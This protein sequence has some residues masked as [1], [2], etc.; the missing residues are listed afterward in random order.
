MPSPGNVC[1]EIR[2][3]FLSPSDIARHCV[4]GLGDGNTASAT[5]KV[6]V[7]RVRDGNKEELHR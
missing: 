3:A 1:K 6:M 2:M 5:R 4:R 7:G